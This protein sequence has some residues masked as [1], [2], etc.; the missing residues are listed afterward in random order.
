M[1]Y[2]FYP[3]WQMGINIPRRQFWKYQQDSQWLFK[4]II[5]K[6]SQ[7]RFVQLNRFDYQNHSTKWLGFHAIYFGLMRY[8]NEIRNSKEKERGGGR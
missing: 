8:N 2:I 7:I 1:D 6:L 4:K 5:Q 3:S